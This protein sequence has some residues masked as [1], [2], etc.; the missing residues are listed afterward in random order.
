ME[1]KLQHPRESDGCLGQ[2]QCGRKKFSL[3]WKCC[4]HITTNKYATAIELLKLREVINVLDH[5]HQQK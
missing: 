1:V 3:K 4:K 5:N 2:K